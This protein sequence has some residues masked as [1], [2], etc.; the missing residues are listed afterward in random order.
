[1]AGTQPPP[2]DAQLMQALFGFN[3]GV[4][5]GQLAIIALIWPVLQWLRRRKLGTVVVDATSFGGAAIGTFALIARV[6][7]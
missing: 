4:E 6:F 5:L 3:M 1:M 7:G 2:P